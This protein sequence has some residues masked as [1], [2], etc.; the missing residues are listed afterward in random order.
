M[1]VLYLADQR[2]L[3]PAWILKSSLRGLILHFQN[4]C[5]VAG[6]ICPLHTGVLVQSMDSSRCIGLLLIRG[7]FLCA[8]EATEKA[9]PPCIIHPKPGGFHRCTVEG[10][11]V[12]VTRLGICK[13]EKRLEPFAIF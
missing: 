8:S 13:P 3:V 2:L 1:A 7:W 12:E 9:D 10:S 11:A 6:N 5:R 4:L